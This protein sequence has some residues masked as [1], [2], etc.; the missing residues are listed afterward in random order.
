[1]KPDY[2]IEELLDLLHRVKRLRYKD[3]DILTIA[4]LEDDRD[5][6]MLAEGFFRIANHLYQLQT[7]RYKQ[8]RS[9]ET[10]LS[11]ERQRA[12]EAERGTGP[13]RIGS[14]DEG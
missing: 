2:T 5:G 14:G 9:T 11:R 6:E 8:G 13:L 7:T 1:M 3:F 10:R 4:H 12:D